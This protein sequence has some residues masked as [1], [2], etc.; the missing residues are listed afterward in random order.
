MINEKRLLSISKSLK[1]SSRD[2]GPRLFN[3]T[4][5]K[6]VGGDPQLKIYKSDFA[7]KVTEVVY[8][9]SVGEYYE[10]TL[11][12]HNTK[13]T[14]R[15]AIVA[16]SG[17][18]TG[19]SPE[20]KRIAGVDKGP[21][22]DIWHGRNSPNYIM[23]DYAFFTNK[24]TATCY[25]NN[26]DKIFVFD[27]YAGWH[28]SHQ[29][30][31]R[32]ISSRAYHSFFMHNMLIR[33][34]LEQLESD[35]FNL[36][37]IVIYNA[38][39]FPA[40]RHTEH[41][42]S[43]TSVD[44]NL[45]TNE[46]VI[47]GTQYA[48]EMKKAVFSLMH[49]LM[50]QRQILTL[51]SSCNVDPDGGN[52]CLFFGL[53][54]TGKTTLSADSS[55]KLIG[56][57]EHSWYGSG[58]FNIEGGC[59]AKVIDFQP[60]KEKEI[61]EAIKFGALFE[62]VIVDNSTRKL[63][64]KDDTLTRNIRLSYPIEFIENAQIPCICGHPKNIILLTCDAFGVLPL[65]SK[66][67]PSQTLYHFMNG[68]TAK[69]AG[70]EM[71]ISEPLATFSACYGEAFLVYR[72]EHYAK[73]LRKKIKAHDVNCWLVNTG[74]VGGK[75]GVGKRCDIDVTREIVRSIHDGSLLK[76]P[77]MKFEAMDLDVPEKY[78]LPVEKWHNK[79]AYQIELNKLMGL[80]ETNF[81]KYDFNLGEC[82]ECDGPCPECSHQH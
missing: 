76:Q 50:P 35:D 71:G 51:H 16:Y 58:V 1:S 64:F 82:E 10:H 21:F 72:P 41:M 17:V 13:I 34:T 7:K 20:D 37:D 59:Y 29:F 69:V 49:Y 74:W 32:V 55:R 45:D 8:N 53:S 22:S 65:V 15:G 57:D 31:V 5:G 9:S 81:A 46:V 68:Y 39:C 3:K 66:L 28:P 38:G 79:G 42:T 48:G 11:E 12:E 19:R 54:G 78:G 6:V 47:L 80:F 43:S 27:G 77:C 63:N 14:E 36:P 23:D 24:E 60:D 56:D 2:F 30:K 18:K 73:M 75:Y 33:P 44:L 62:N 52:P 40:N 4:L 26:M 67:T 25:L 70:T 61:N